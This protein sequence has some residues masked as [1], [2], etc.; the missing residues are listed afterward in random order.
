M[1]NKKLKLTI[2]AAAFGALL[3]IGGVS[4]SADTIAIPSPTGL[5]GRSNVSQEGASVAQFVYIEDY[6]NGYL[7]YDQWNKRYV[8]F[9]TRNPAETVFMWYQKI[10]CIQCKMILGDV[11]G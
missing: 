5:T 9:V 10:L 11:Y 8:Y 3:F 1:K 4:A 2:I 7:A 6:S